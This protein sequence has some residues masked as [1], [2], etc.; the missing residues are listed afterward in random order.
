MPPSSRR[1]I[2]ST[3]LPSPM[4][5]SGW[6][7]CGHTLSTTRSDD[8]FAEAYRGHAAPGRRRR[9][10]GHR[11]DPGPLAGGHDDALRARP[12]GTPARGGRPAREG[13]RVS[14]PRRDAFSVGVP[15]VIDGCYQIGHEP[16]G[17][18]ARH[19]TDPSGGG[20]QMGEQDGP[21][22]LDAAWRD[23]ER[24]VRKAF[25]TERGWL[26]L[27]GIWLGFLVAGILT[28]LGLWPGGIPNP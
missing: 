27:A 3:C 17:R 21:A 7:R 10:A 14:T 26:L 1:P 16:D 2:T 4:K 19:Q 22:R 6:K 13:A 23:F 12:A 18:C 25:I 5:W 15:C 28:W 20:D 24:E 9:P 11:L 8:A